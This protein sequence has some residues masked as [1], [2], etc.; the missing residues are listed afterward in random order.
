MI[1]M[2]NTGGSRILVIFRSHRLTD[3]TVK[4]KDGL[5]RI[6]NWK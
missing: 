3:K 5:C 6:V 4:T 2:R 1:S